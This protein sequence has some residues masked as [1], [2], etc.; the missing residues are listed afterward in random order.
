MYH[1]MGYVRALFVLNFQLVNFGW[2]NR[3]KGG[4]KNTNDGVK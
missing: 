3:M 1:P 4:K 2:Q